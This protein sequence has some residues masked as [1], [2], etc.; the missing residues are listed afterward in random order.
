MAEIGD[1]LD[2]NPE[3]GTTTTLLGLTK[4]E[5]QRQNPYKKVQKTVFKHKCVHKIQFGFNNLRW[6]PLQY[7]I[8]DMTQWGKYVEYLLQSDHTKKID[9]TQLDC[10]LDNTLYKVFLFFFIDKIPK[11]AT[12]AKHLEKK[13]TNFWLSALINSTNLLIISLINFH[14]W[15]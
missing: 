12:I 2:C 8:W 5:I 1:Y 10:S 15:Y 14:E 4:E 11:M 3:P 7:Q 13:S 9:E 6:Q